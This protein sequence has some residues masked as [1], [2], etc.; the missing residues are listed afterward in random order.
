MAAMGYLPWHTPVRQAHRAVGLNSSYSENHT[1][2]IY[3][4]VSTLV[5]KGDGI[6]EFFQLEIYLMGLSFLNKENTWSG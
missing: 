3:K 5:T 4:L 6:I 2:S 1:L